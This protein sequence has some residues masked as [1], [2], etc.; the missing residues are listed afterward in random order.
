MKSAL[1]S[2]FWREATLRKVTEQWLSLSSDL[3]PVNHSVLVHRILACAIP[4]IETEARAVVNANLRFLI[5]AQSNASQMTDGVSLLDFVRLSLRF[6]L[7]ERIAQSVLE[8][9]SVAFSAP[10]PFFSLSQSQ[11]E[12]DACFATWFIPSADRNSAVR[13]L[14]NGMTW[15][16]RMSST[17]N[18]F[19]VEALD[20]DGRIATHIRFDPL[21]VRPNAR[22]FANVAG[23]EKGAESLRELLSNV[24]ELTLPL[25]QGEPLKQEKVTFVEGA[26]LAATIKSAIRPTLDATGDFLFRFGLQDSQFDL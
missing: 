22:F 20:E 4:P 17:P 1:G 11:H 12:V 6:G 7:L 8:V 23:E 2:D 24:L 10:H 14:R 15:I 25:F 3:T 26:V 13:I 21:S 9:S 16:V 18:C 5:S 19:T